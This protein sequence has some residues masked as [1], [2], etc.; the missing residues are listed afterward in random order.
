VRFFDQHEIEDE[1]R[2][3]HPD[4]WTLA[5]TYARLGDKDE[6]VKW[7]EKLYEEH[8]ATLIQIKVDSDLDGLHSDPRYANLL[9]RIGFP[10]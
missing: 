9:R 4:G 10:P 6:A 7:L 5:Y 1:K 2:Q 8:S 3:P